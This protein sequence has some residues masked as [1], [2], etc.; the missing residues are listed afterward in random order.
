M[1]LD[2]GDNNVS[3]ECSTQTD[4]GDE[5]GD[6]HLFYIPLQPGK[7]GSTSQ[8]IIQGVTVKLGTE[9][10]S[11]PNQRVVMRAKLIT[12]PDNRAKLIT[13]PDNQDKLTTPDN[14]LV[15]TGQQKPLGQPTY[16]CPPVG[17]VQPTYRPKHSADG[18]KSTTDTETKQTVPSSPS[19]S[20]SSSAKIYKKMSKPRARLLEACRPIN[21]SE[22]PKCGSRPQLVEAL[23]F[24]PNE[25]EFQDPIEFIDKIRPMAE[26]FGI[27][28]IIPPSNFKPECKVTD[29][30]RFSAYNQY[31]HKMLH[32]W[33]PNFKEFMAI[34][35][36]LATQSITFTHPPW[37]S[38]IFLVFYCNH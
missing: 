27:C 31:V 4:T 33:G 10:I 32:R 24:H 37:V 28:R 19:A 3:M 36:Y 12:T 9:G 16:M 18:Q 38:K 8:P 25:R 34:K 20:S 1:N 35:K 6:S 30:M 26:K 23:T 21:S 13:T 14:H 17:T 22:F 15:T 7:S 2:S 11:G 5:D 29:D